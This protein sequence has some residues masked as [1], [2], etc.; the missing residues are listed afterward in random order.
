MF[1]DVDPLVEAV[2]VQFFL[3][4]GVILGNLP[5]L[6][7]GVGSPVTFGVFNACGIG[8]DVCC[9]DQLLVPA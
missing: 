8:F 9:S 4:R 6:H 7:P 5:E 3:H 1:E 2:F